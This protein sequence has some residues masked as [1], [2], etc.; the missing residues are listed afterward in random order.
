VIEVAADKITLHGKTKE[1]SE[2]RFTFQNIFL[3]DVTQ[4]LFFKT[5]VKDI[6]ENS[7]NGYNGTII[8]YGQV[9]L[10]PDRIRKN[11]HYIRGAQ[12]DAKYRQGKLP[13][14]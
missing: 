4:E 13:L 1:E 5:N 9:N 11:T 8:A 14:N 3:P 7:L 6:V 10:L 2:K 12:N